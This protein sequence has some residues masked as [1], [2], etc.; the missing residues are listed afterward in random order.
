VTTS[1][2]FLGVIAAATLIMAIIQVGLIIGGL[3]LAKRV[4]AAVDRIEEASR[5]II[6]RLDQVTTEALTSMA[7]ARAQMERLE[8][9]TTDMVDR[10]DQA[11]HRIQTYVLAPA[12]QGIA[13]LAGARAAVQAFK[14]LPFSR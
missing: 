11:A 13:L 9:M 3:I 2:I 7:A 5:P 1:E 14:R 12:R 8:Q 6:D 4:T 10:V